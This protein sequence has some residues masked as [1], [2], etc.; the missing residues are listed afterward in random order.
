[1]TPEQ[2]LN[3]VSTT[4]QQSPP[5]GLTS[6]YIQG[7]MTR[8]QEGLLH[9]IRKQFNRLC[10]PDALLPNVE[11]RLGYLFRDE[12]SSAQVTVFAREAVQTGIYFLAVKARCHPMNPVKA[13]QFAVHDKGLGPWRIHPGEEWHGSPEAAITAFAQA[14]AQEVRWQRDD[15][16]EVWVG[17]AEAP[18]VLTDPLAIEVVEETLVQRKEAEGLATHRQRKLFAEFETERRAGTSSTTPEIKSIVMDEVKAHPSEDNGLHTAAHNP[19]ATEATPTPW[20]GLRGAPLANESIQKGMRV[21]TSR[22]EHGVVDRVDV[23]VWRVS[24]ITTWGAQTSDVRQEKSYSFEVRLDS[25]REEHTTQL[26]PELAP[27]QAV[28]PDLDLGDSAGLQSPSDVW[29]RVQGLF[30]AI[31][32]LK[33][34][35]SN[36]RK[37]QTKAQ[38]RQEAQQVRQSFE[39]VFRLFHT[40]RTRYPAAILE[41]FD[42]LRYRILTLEAGLRSEGWEAELAWLNA[43]PPDWRQRFKAGDRVL[44]PAFRAIGSPAEQR[45][46]IRSIEGFYAVMASDS[47]QIPLYLLRTVPGQALP[48]PEY[49]QPMY[50]I[51]LAQDLL[52]PT[53][54]PRGDVTP[55]YPER[56]A[57]A[58]SVKSYLAA[59]DIDVRTRV[60]TGANM[61][62]IELHPPASERWDAET[63]TRL[64][65]RL[66]GLGAR[67]DGATFHPWAKEGTPGDP[68]TDYYGT[69]SGIFLD[70]QQLAAF[71]P[72]LAKGLKEAGQALS[73]N[74]EAWLATLER[75]PS[76]ATLTTSTAPAAATTGCVDT[77]FTLDGYGLIRIVCG[78]RG[79]RDVWH[80][81]HVAST[82]YGFNGGRW[83]R[84]LV[85]PQA[86][87][88]ALEQRGIRA[89]S[90]VERMRETPS[91]LQ[92]DP[93]IRELI[94]NGGLQKDLISDIAPELRPKARAIPGLLRPNG[95]TWLA[96]ATLH[97]SEP[98]EVEVVEELPPNHWLSD[99]SYETPESY[100]ELVHFALETSFPEVE[101]ED[102]DAGDERVERLCGCGAWG[103]GKE[104]RKGRGR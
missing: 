65:Q 27:P 10:R 2:L 51:H 11:R 98:G 80:N 82:R 7:F 91:D 20:G 41:D 26:F 75:A 85:P 96:L 43:T 48:P 86:V 39:G 32:R 35:S 3:A 23:T 13:R 99:I 63:L 54:G 46:R 5:P 79:K 6:R 52:A 12:T 67:W 73:R 78:A 101:E 50:L 47:V 57:V 40:W 36:A 83:A 18:Y 59:N 90:S 45:D 53:S 64:E 93:V 4:L 49:S 89:F 100:R 77:T 24:G 97:Y 71:A 38:Y 70:P 37:L 19:D 76:T 102:E 58:K 104:D 72:Y 60:Q 56:G 69:P 17:R 34:K 62:G 44:R 84:G 28:V 9:Q 31:G 15:E 92:L 103:N 95:K 8:H 94:A 88:D 1:M 14:H 74:G 66:P 55:L 25:G 61:T 29:R 21:V 16:P 30:S 68:N 87:L 42:P 81:I 22:G 33:E